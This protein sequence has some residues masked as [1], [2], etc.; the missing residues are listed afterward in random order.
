MRYLI[1]HN[2]ILKYDENK[3]VKQIEIKDDVYFLSY[4]VTGLYL[5]FFGS[6]DL[7]QQ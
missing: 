3:K 7:Y 5:G 6:L 4:Y 1:L 2:C